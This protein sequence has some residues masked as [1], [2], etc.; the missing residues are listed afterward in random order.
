MRENT[1]IFHFDRKNLP[2]SAGGCQQCIRTKTG[3]TDSLKGSACQK[4]ELEYYV[5]MI[6][7]A[8]KAAANAEPARAFADIFRA[9]TH[10]H[11]ATQ[12]RVPRLPRGG[13]RMCGALR[14]RL[15]RGAMRTLIKHVC[16]H[17]P[18]STSL[19]KELASN[20]RHGFGRPFIGGI[21]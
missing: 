16:G 8:R 2:G 17:S 18:M 11:T 10:E 14:E 13:A 1:R 19:K 5:S 15:R 21:L 12:R 9:P 20:G 4:S 3:F 7:S 6:K